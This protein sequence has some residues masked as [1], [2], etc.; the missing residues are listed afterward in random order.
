MSLTKRNPTGTENLAMAPKLVLTALAV[1]LLSPAAL[2]AGGLPRVCLPVDGVT[3]DNAK[4][5][6][7]L[8]AGAFGDR[9]DRV[10]LRENDE[11]WYA[12]FSVNAAEVD[13]GKLDAAFKGGPFSVPRDKLRLFGHAVLEIDI[14]AASEEKL[15]TD[16]KALRNLTVEGAKRDKG[17]LFVT[18]IA[19]YPPHTG[20]EVDEFGKVSFAKERFG[21]EKSDFGPKADPPAAPRDLPALAAMRA[22]AEKH[23][24][25]VKGVRLKLLGCHV[26]GGVVASDVKPK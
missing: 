23:G 19:P 24:G 7:K 6:T 11:Q 26:Q 1:A 21:V 12:L 18:V 13:L 22:A 15:L 9:A 5:C 14:G 17:V 3:A 16:L 20:R 8:I 2:T 4:A 25:T 10:E